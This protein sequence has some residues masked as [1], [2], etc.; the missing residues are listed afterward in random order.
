MEQRPRMLIPLPEAPALHS[1]IASHFFIDGKKPFVKNTHVCS[2][3]HG[4]ETL[5]LEATDGVFAHRTRPVVVFRA[6][7]DLVQW[8]GGG[9]GRNRPPRAWFSPLSDGNQPWF[10]LTQSSFI[11]AIAIGDLIK[12]TLGPKGMDKIL[13]SYRFVFVS[14]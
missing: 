9:K 11:G 4:N 12:S 6:C 8:R 14:P 7:S 2:E 13:Q 5:W 1:W 3:H 10:F